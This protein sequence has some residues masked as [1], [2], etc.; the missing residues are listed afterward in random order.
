ML[1]TRQHE[2]SIRVVIADD[3]HFV[4]KG[5][6]QFLS[7]ENEIEVVAEC[8]DGLDALKAIREQGPDILVLDLRM[9]RM[10]GLELLARMKEESIDTPVVLLVGNISDD[11]MLEAMRF[12]VKGVVLK[13]MAPELLVQCIQKVSSGGQWL[14]KQSVARL[15]E[16]MLRNEKAVEEPLPE[17][18][19]REREIVAMVASG[20]TNRDIAGKLFISE[21]TVKSHLH[22][23]FEKLGVSSRMQLS[24]F[25]RNRGLV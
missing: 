22:T 12:G 17:L 9:P 7:E 15:L 20:L 6:M 25:A 19:T 13:E 4:R 11:E 1:A 10:N 8:A 14:E 16:R 3:H 2:A 5:L 21:A 18:T 23:V 24:I